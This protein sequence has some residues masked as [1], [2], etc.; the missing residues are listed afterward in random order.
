MNFKPEKV[1]SLLNDSDLDAI[2]AYCTTAIHEA[3]AK[4]T[5]GNIELKRFKGAQRFIKAIIKDMPYRSAF[6]GALTVDGVQMM[7]NGCVGFMFE[8]DN[9]IAN[10]PE[11]DSSLELMD[12]K[13]CFDHP[14]ITGTAT[15][16]R[17]EVTAALK[18]HKASE[19]SKKPCYYEVGMSWY[20][21]RYLIGLLD[22]IGADELTLDQT[23]DLQPAFVNM[24][25]IQAIILPIRK[26][27]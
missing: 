5:G 22:I 17:A 24:D 20:D 19:N 12:L 25:G 7:C 16:T 4:A 10:L 26:A 6:H 2:R 18:L 13:K 9:H 21:V 11:I 15:F 8:P 27:S 23:H 1:L 14:A 3:S